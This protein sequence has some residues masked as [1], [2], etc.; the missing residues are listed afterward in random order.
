MKEFWRAWFSYSRAER[1]GIMVLLVFI[2]LLTGAKF[3]LPQWIKP[4]LAADFSQFEQEIAAFESD[5]IIEINGATID[6]LTRLKGI[7]PVLAENI[8]IYRTALGG[9]IAKEQLN[10]AKGI[11]DSK[12]EDIAP[13]ITVDT[14]SIKKIAINRWTLEQLGAH[15]YVG[16]GLAK[17]ILK[18]R[19]KGGKI[20]NEQD[21]RTLKQL[22]PEK[23]E[24]LRPYLDYK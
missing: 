10:E 15:P 20:K 4:Q 7:G 24:K 17:A 14:D 22:K 12:Y 21:L 16:K 1:L 23:L 6:G 2:G 13:F 19:E 5:T 8:I 3:L 11:G 18:K 9:F